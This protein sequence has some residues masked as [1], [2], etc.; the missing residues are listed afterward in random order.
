VYF[1]ATVV[2]TA[3][4][5]SRFELGA[6]WR[7]GR[8][9]YYDANDF[10]TLIVSAIPFGLY[11]VL[12]RRRLLV[13][14]LAVLGLAVL[15]VGLIRSGSRGG[16]LALLAVTAFFLLGFTAVPAR[17]RLMGLGLVLAVVFATANDRY[18][19][20]MQ[21]ILNPHQDYNVTSDAGRLKIWERGLGYLAERPVAGVGMS[22]FQVAEGTISPQ[23]RR[24]AG[25]RPVFW[26]A[27]HN[28]LVQVGAELGVPGLLLLIGLF[29]SVF[30][31]L[32][33]VARRARNATPPARDVSR[34]VQTLQAA[35][36]GFVVGAFF[37]SLAYTDM[38]YTL[39]ALA[40]G[41]Q[42]VTRD[43]L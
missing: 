5:L 22:N 34:L 6:D 1:G 27:P 30:A 13:R 23:A 24:Q 7:L 2:Y 20:Q 42:K 41:L 12:A 43:R 8:L 38:L 14:V 40:L 26:Q 10:A 9:Y 21:T 39:V 4:V 35:L 15:A 36:V 19:T 31:S 25:G 11:V 33:R 17:A 3:V 29:A 18:W 16:L 32:R 37:L 28:T